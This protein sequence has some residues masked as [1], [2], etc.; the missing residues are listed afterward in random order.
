MLL[1][2]H[3]KCSFFMS[4]LEAL[5]VLEVDCIWMIL[6]FLP[7]CAFT[8]GKSLLQT[9]ALHIDSQ[10]IGLWN[11]VHVL[12]WP[13]LLFICRALNNWRW[14][15]QQL[16]SIHFPRQF[17]PKCSITSFILLKYV[18][19]CFLF[20]LASYLNLFRMNVKPGIE[21]DFSA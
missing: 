9:T 8:P 2:L 13:L 10:R 3:S 17:F 20:S 14:Y 7:S 15:V 11:I 4:N 18:T 21:K 19:S 5:R 1:L 6:V 16:I 12:R